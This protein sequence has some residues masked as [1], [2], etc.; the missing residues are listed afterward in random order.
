MNVWLELKRALTVMDVATRNWGRELG[1]D[2][3]G[4][5]V[6]ALLGEEGPALEWELAMK[7]GRA[8]QQVHRSLGVMK[9]RRLVEPELAVPGRNKPWQLTPTGREL[10]RCLDRGI[11]EW[12]RELEA[13]M[14]L[15]ELRSGLQRIVE[16]F[17]NRPRVNGGWRRALSVPVELLKMPIHVHA[18]VE[19]LLEV[20]EMTLAPEAPSEPEPEILS[21]P[22]WGP[23]DCWTP[24]ERAFIAQYW[25]SLW[26][27]DPESAAHEEERA[28]ERI[29]RW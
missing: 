20:P 17:L 25:R 26:E 28:R 1:L 7:C 4:A 29:G 27:S 3:C 14:E 8:R 24:Q 23:P 18:E 2:E 16:I 22:G 12:Q 10:W 15:A 13:K 19:G 5:M 6:L 9:K 11:R 21:P